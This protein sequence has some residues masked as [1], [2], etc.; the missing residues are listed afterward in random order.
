M[1]ELGKDPHDE[2]SGVLLLWVG[3][4]MAPIVWLVQF[5]VRYALVE[6]ICARQSRIVLHLLSVFFFL[7]MVA[8]GMFCWRCWSRERKIAPPE[9]ESSPRHRNVFLSLLGMLSSSLFALVLIAQ[10]IAEVMVEPCQ[11]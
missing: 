2:R 3:V 11:N 10:A 6:W 8:G 1:G 9:E 4:L 5:E 7:T